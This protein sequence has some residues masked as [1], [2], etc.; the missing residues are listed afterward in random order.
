MSILIAL[1]AGHGNNTPGKRTPYFND[2]TFMRENEFN[3]ATLKY[4]KSM[5]ERCGFSTLDV[6]PEAYDVPL[7][8]RVKRA[9]ATNASLYV[10]IHANAYG[11]G[12]NE[13][14]GVETW[15]YEKSGVSFAVALKVQNEMI[16]E[17]RLKDRGVK[18]NKQLYVLNS[19]KMSALLV[20]CG[21][22]T[23]KYE[24]T[25]LKS[26]EYRKKCAKA[27]C[28]G[29]CKYYNVPYIEEK[30]VDDEVVEKAVMIVDGKEIQV[31][32]IMKN[33]TNYVKIRDLADILGYDVSNVGS[34]AVLNKK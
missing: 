13:A 5:L 4:L 26:E 19:T 27:I 10:S 8:T 3:K 7:Q 11:S 33:G 29:I 21:F 17:T 6:A 16:V 1:D 14:N 23:N 15:V 32:R 2:G 20:E 30:G 22:M 9:N 12:W 24:A 18:E 25:L 28:K 34:T 31:E